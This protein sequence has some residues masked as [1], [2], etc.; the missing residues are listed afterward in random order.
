MALQTGPGRDV[1]WRIWLI[2]GVGFAVFVGL[3][4]WLANGQLTTGTVVGSAI[5]GLIFGGAMALGHTRRR[6]KL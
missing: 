6:A 2:Y 5:G 1:I 4:L 3:I